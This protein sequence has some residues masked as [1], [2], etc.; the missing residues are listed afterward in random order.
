MCLSP[1][2]SPCGA[3]ALKALL[4]FTPD[5]YG[6]GDPGSHGDTH[7]FCTDSDAGVGGGQ[8]SLNK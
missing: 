8:E 7:L 3:A 4:V 1:S 5:K 6:G 2:C